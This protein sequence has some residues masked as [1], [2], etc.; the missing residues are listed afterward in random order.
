M[1]RFII[2]VLGGLCF[3]AQP[4]VAY[5]EPQPGFIRFPDVGATQ[6]VFVYAD[7]LWVVAKQGGM[8]VRLTD[9]RDPKSYPR[10]SP[11]GKTIAFTGA[12]NG[13]YTIPIAGGSAN[14]IT[15]HPGST[16]VCDW[17]P[18]GQVLFMTDAF[19][20]IFD[21]DDQARFRQL[22]T[23][24][25]RG[26]LPHKLEVPYGAH[27]SISPDGQWLA[28][29]VYANGLSEAKKHYFGGY[30][31]DIWLFNLRNHQSKKITDWKG[32]D[33][34]PMWNGEAIYYISDGGPDGRLNIWSY[35]TRSGR[36]EQITH[37]KDFDVKWPSIGPGQRGQGEI[38]FVHGLDLY[39]LDLSPKRSRKIRVAIP[40]NIDKASA[41]VDASKF[42]VN[43]RLSPDGSQSLIE[44]RGDIWVVDHATG[45]ARGV[46]RTSGA[47]ERD[48]AWSP[49][50]DWIS[51]LSDASGEYELTISRADGSGSPRQLTQLGRGFRY[52]PVWSPD[53]EQIAFY[54]RT[55][56]IYLHTLDGG[57]TKKI[58]R[59]P[60]VGHPQMSWSPDSQWLAYAR[61][62]TSSTRYTSIWLHSMGEGRS[63]EVTSGWFNDTWPIF[64]RTG[65]YL[66]FVSARNFSG[67]TITFDSVEDNNFIYPSADLLL[68][69]PL[70]TGLGPPW[71]H[72]TKA[73]GP[74]SEKRSVKVDLNDFERRAV[75]ALRDKGAYSNLA[76]ANSGELIFTFAPPDG[77]TAVK[78]IDFSGGRDPKVI[79]TGV[80]DFRMSADGRKMLVRNDNGLFVIDA[81]PQQKLEKP[82]KPDRMTVDIDLRAE[83]QQIF[84][85]AWRLYRDFFYDENMR[86]IDWLAMRTKYSKLAALCSRRD[87]IYEVIFEMIGELGSSHVSLFQPAG[88]QPPSGAISLHPSYD[89]LL[90]GYENTGML[91]VDFEVSQGAYRIVKIYQGAPWDT[92]PGNPLS[93]PGVD[94]HEGSYLLAVNGVRL[95]TAKDPWSAFKGLAETN[96]QLTVSDKPVIDETARNVTVDLLDRWGEIILR[97][98]AWIETNRSQV[99]SKTDGKIGYLY[100]ANTHVYGFREFTRQLN[101]QLD[102]QAWIID[103]RWNEGG[104]M[105]LHIIEVLGRQSY[106]YELFRR[107]A[108]PVT[109]P[110]YMAGGPKCL[111]MNG[112]TLSGG[113]LLAYFFRKRGLGKLIGTTTMGAN[114]GIIGGDGL[115]IRY[116]DGGFSSI[117]IEWFND[118]TGALAIEGYGV[119]PDITV[120][121]DPGLMWNGGDP[122]L[123]RAIQQ[124]LTEIK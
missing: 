72:E 44:A 99:D 26:G 67:T 107:P 50:G 54:D 14:R 48:P 4:I 20:P 97:N 41:T 123:D 68:S 78:E 96:V 82:V 111:L 92:F 122:Q 77:E 109:V 103:G 30:A 98:R 46:T 86:G 79:V 62:A 42:M 89:Q 73:N 102:K 101:G 33:T 119:E 94:V 49:N 28:Y 65:D 12:Y 115:G 74:T 3:L 38:V 34:I 5:G 51:Y 32:T 22:F 6:I 104:H 40:N 88:E 45:T 76:I 53:S 112:V 36:R 9:T 117:P 106:L 39:L 60:L 2:G 58:D 8:A 110:S 121:D 118:E 43:W 29:T 66:Y 81:A 114:V 17:T 105:P 52:R 27:G 108:G 56:S 83:G 18:D 61:G 16:T 15:H 63:H 69:V 57:E 93:A 24:L 47:A 35:E 100:L 70:R 80:N 90:G 64:D 19:A 1:V 71:L 7:E 91:A 23:V 13:V 55:G 75:V 87:D 31:P 59:D 116:V 10:L 84:M 113:D 85:D 25:A 95:D 120:I 11:D 37:F 21:N 124:L